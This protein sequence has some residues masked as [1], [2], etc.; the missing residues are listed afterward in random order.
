MLSSSIRTPQY[1]V[2]HNRI[3]LFPSAAVHLRLSQFPARQLLHK[4]SACRL[5]V[6]DPL[7]LST[8]AL[9]KTLCFIS[10]E[11]S[12]FFNSCSKLM[13]FSLQKLCKRTQH[14]TTD[15]PFSNCIS[16]YIQSRPHPCIISSNAQSIFIRNE[17][18]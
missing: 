11:L 10:I 5:S 17:L 9:R 12:F 13:H 6:C 3:E 4:H 14:P 18:C 1:I 16:S 15:S 7:S 2:F 8:A